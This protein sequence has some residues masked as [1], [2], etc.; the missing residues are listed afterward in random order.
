[1]IRYQSLNIICQTPQ[2]AMDNF[3]G[4]INTLDVLFQDESY[5]TRTGQ[6]AYKK[7]NNSFMAIKDDIK[8]EL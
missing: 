3:L 7:F 6:K 4:N 8:T 2:N 1:M 5:E